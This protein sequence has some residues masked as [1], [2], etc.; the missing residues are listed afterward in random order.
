MNCMPHI[1]KWKKNPAHLSATFKEELVVEIFLTST[2]LFKLN[3]CKSL[4]S[5]TKRAA[6][7]HWGQGEGGE[8]NICKPSELYSKF[9][10]SKSHKDTLLYFFTKWKLISWVQYMC[11]HFLCIHHMK[12]FFKSFPFLVLNGVFIYLGAIIIFS[13]VLYIQWVFIHNHEETKAA[14]RKEGKVFIFSLFLDHRKAF[15]KKSEMWQVLVS[16]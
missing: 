8:G 7:L 6:I 14:K 10:L 13:I 9:K 16:R 2:V 3:L 5:C 11:K 4:E 1:K 15:S 12:V